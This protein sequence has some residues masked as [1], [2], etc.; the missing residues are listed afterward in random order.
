MKIVVDVEELE[1]R[2]TVQVAVK[3]SSINATYAAAVDLDKLG[4]SIGPVIERIVRRRPFALVEVPEGMRMVEVGISWIAFSEVHVAVPNN[5]PD[6][7]QELRDAIRA[8]I[9]RDGLPEVVDNPTLE[10]IS[11]M[12]AYAPKGPEGFVMAPTTEIDIE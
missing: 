7:G 6:D 4:E 8:A 2:C 5:T 3:H 9:K 11:G 1:G 10:F 12:N